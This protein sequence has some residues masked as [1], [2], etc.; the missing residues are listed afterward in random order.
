MRNHRRAAYN[1]PGAEYEEVSVVP[2]G[3]DAS[4][5]PP[6]LLAAARASWDRALELGEQ[7][8]YRNAQAT[9]IA[10]TG[11]LVGNSLVLTD[12]GLSR[13]NRL[14]QAD[15]NKWQDVFFKV[16]TDEGERPATRFFVNGVENTRKITTASGYTIQGTPTHRVKVVNTATGTMEWKRVSEVQPTDIV[17]LSMGK[18]VGT[19]RTV[20]LP[21]LGEEYWTT[22]SSTT[23]PREMS[24][25]LAELV[26]HWRGG[27]DAPA[28]GEQHREAVD[29]R[30]HRSG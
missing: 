2:M 19:P 20:R 23:V 25:E 24:A 13:L 27:V 26:T 9:C 16:L 14:G 21:S 17:A 30:A 5:C 4:L 11:C 6:Y 22:D 12:R 1:A 3:I 15:G 29:D 8:G 28:L 10:P 18:F 7:H